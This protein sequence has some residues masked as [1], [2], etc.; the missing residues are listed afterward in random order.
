MKTPISLILAAAIIGGLGIASTPASASPAEKAA[1][2]ACKKEMGL[3]G[4][5]HQK[6]AFL[7]STC[8]NQKLGR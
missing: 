7:L 3:K 8:V 6:T 1:V 5:K 2:K 4:R